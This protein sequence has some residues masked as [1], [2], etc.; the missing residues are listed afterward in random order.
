MYLIRCISY[1]LRYAPAMGCIRRGFATFLERRHRNGAYGV[2]T[3]STLVQSEH[4]RETFNLVPLKFG[5]TPLDG[6]NQPADGF[7]LG[8]AAGSLHSSDCW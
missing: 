3:G 4:H 5:A 7:K 1:R 6:T 8:A 2:P